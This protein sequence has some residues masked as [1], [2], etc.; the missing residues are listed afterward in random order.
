MPIIYIYNTE[1]RILS[2]FPENI[3]ID[4]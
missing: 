1:K 2:F 4:K 3:Y